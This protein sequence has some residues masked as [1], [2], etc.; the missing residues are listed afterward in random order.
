MSLDRFS[1]GLVLYAA[2]S[3]AYFSKSHAAAFSRQ[4]Q[5]HIPILI[6]SPE[7]KRVPTLPGLFLVL[8]GLW[9]G[10]R[11]DQTVLVKGND[12]AGGG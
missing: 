3:R 8:P 2:R 4:K 11:V 10:F 1:H 7:T 12:K 5:H 9:G 6:T